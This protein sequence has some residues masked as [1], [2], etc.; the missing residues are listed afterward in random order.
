MSLVIQ[1]PVRALNLIIMDVLDKV[2]AT[3][4]N[5][6]VKALAEDVA[7]KLKDKI[8]S[9]DFNFEKYSK[10]YSQWKET[11]YPGSVPLMASGDYVEAIEVVKIGSGYSVGVRDDQHFGDGKVPIHMRDLARIL[12]YGCPKRNIPPRPHWRPALA[13]LRRRK[14]AV[15]QELKAKLSIDIQKAMDEYLSQPRNYEVRHYGE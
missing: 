11:H 13:N 15:S 6:E 8:R 7:M 10:E 9:N 3:R 14:A 2:V 5:E 12:E 1:K 4:G